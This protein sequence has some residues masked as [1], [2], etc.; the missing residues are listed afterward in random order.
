MRLLGVAGIALVAGPL[1][2]SCGASVS[3]EGEACSDCIM[4]GYV[5]SDGTSPYT[6]RCLRIAGTCTAERRPCPG[7]DCATTECGPPIRMASYACEDGTT[8]GPTG[9]CRRETSGS[10]AWEIRTCVRKCEPT[11]CDVPSIACADGSLPT[12]GPCKRA[13]DGRCA[14]TTWT[15]PKPKPTCDGPHTCTCDVAKKSMADEICTTVRAGGGDCVVCLQSVDPSG[16]QC[17]WS[18]LYMPAECP[19][20]APMT[21][22]KCPG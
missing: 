6:G 1:V 17:Q 13:P 18:A 4:L 22:P 19:C 14:V 10:C 7:E 2:T 15:C 12:F 21:L 16:V 20:P 11:E 5:C 8:G 9:R 3:T